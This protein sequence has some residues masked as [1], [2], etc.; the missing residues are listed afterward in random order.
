LGVAAVVELAKVSIRSS[1]RGENTYIILMNDGIGGLDDVEGV[2]HDVG[3]LAELV[4]VLRALRKRTRDGELMVISKENIVVPRSVEAGVLVEAT[5]RG[6]L[7]S[8]GKDG[9]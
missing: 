1:L 8:H 2:E 7:A 4:E 9:K 3:G 5:G 6:V